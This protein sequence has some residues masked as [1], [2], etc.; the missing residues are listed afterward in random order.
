[1]STESIQE[2]DTVPS[3]VFLEADPKE[4]KKKLLE[5]AAGKA[6]EPRVLEFLGT[7]THEQVRLVL[8]GAKTADRKVIFERAT[9]ERRLLLRS[10]D[11]K[12]LRV[13]MKLLVERDPKVRE[14][15]VRQQVSPH[16]KKADRA[17]AEID[18]K[19]FF[20]AL[21][22]D[23]ELFPWAE[24]NDFCWAAGMP[25]T[26]AATL[27]DG[28]LEDVREREASADLLNKEGIL[29]LAYLLE[30]VVNGNRWKMYSRFETMALER[31]QHAL[32]EGFNL[33]QAAAAWTDA[34]KSARWGE[35]ME[36]AK[37]RNGE[38]S[39]GSKD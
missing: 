15:F 36:C 10:M 35:P 39:D 13:E 11:P 23:G 17:R 2:S 21:A 18:A 28:W 1:M 8:K 22:D 38:F 25:P 3:G 33:T 12:A 31:L 20:D 14:M 6:V 34:R 16:S 9:R 19:E 29:H 7:A 32:E 5:L 37:R 26:E 27:A 24:M 30:D 4:L